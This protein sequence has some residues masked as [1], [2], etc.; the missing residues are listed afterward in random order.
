LL[1]DRLS[2]I[3]KLNKS[4]DRLELSLTTGRPAKAGARTTPYAAVRV[5]KDT[6]WADAFGKY[7]NF[8]LVISR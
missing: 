5:S 4:I 7:P 6:A 2:F 3:F 8:C 1:S